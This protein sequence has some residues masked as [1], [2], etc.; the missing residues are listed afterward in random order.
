MATTI[1]N[2]TDNLG[3]QDLYTP[4]YSF[5]TKAIGQKQSEYDRGFNAFKSI[6]K[7]R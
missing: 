4:D 3:P 6:C 5:L 2:V 1:P 7:N